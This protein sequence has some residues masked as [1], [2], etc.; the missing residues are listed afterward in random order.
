MPDLI[1]AMTIPRSLLEVKFGRNYW[2]STGNRRSGTY[3][4]NVER[5]GKV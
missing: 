5:Q 3:N 4:K 2:A 1:F